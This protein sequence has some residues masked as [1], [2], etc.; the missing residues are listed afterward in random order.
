MIKDI[1]EDI[2][3]ATENKA[4][5]SALALAL[6]IPDI[7]SKIEYKDTK[8]K[9]N[10]KYIEWFNKWIY[11]YFEIP[12][13]NN[14]EFDSYDELAIFDGKVCYA[15]RCAYLHAGNYELKENGKNEIGIDRFEL[16]VSDGEWQFGDSHGC[17]ISNDTIIDV[18]RRFNVENL[19][20]YFIMGT[21]D[22]ISEVGDNSEKYGTVDIIRFDLKGE[23]NEQLYN[24]TW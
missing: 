24:I 5:F 13:S 9:K 11:K 17:S 23:D 15:L 1:L 19:I 18:H 14:E 2:K 12:K 21:E 10:E 16:C 20:K 6:T 8:L 3:L 7:C 22:Y 4:Y